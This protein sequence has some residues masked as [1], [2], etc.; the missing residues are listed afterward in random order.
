[1]TTHDSTYCY[2]AISKQQTYP[3]LNTLDHNQK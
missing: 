2:S 3:T 1:M